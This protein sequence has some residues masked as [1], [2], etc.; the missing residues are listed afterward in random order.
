[1]NKILRPAIFKKNLQLK[2]SILGAQFH[3]GESLLPKNPPK[4]AQVSTGD[5]KFRALILLHKETRRCIE[6]FQKGT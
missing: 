2:K 6:V 1:M 3:Q 5:C 4:S